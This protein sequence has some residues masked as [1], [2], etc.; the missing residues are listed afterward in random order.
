MRE[1]GPDI[2]ATSLSDLS[3]QLA[4]FSGGATA[5]NPIKVA[6]TTINFAGSMLKDLY[7]TLG[8]HNKYIDLDLSG[9][10]NSV[11]EIPNDAA[12]QYVIGQDYI[13]GITFPNIT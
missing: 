10:D 7:Q 3:T 9:L 12:T 1:G 11:T 8:S 2:T 6:L 5:G 13:V 4:A